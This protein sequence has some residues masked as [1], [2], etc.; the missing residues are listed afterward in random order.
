MYKWVNVNSGKA[1]DV[2]DYSLDLG[3]TVQQWSYNG[4]TNQMWCL[5]EVGSGT[6]NAIE[7]INS[8]YVLDV[9][10]WPTYNF[11][12]QAIQQWWK[13]GYNQSYG[14]PYGVC[15]KNEQFQMYHLGSGRY[16]L[17]SAATGK[18]ITVTGGST[19]DG[20]AV[21]QNDSTGGNEQKW[22]LV[23]V[24]HAWSTPSY[25]PGFWN[26]YSYQRVANNC[27]NYGNN[28]RT[29][30][31]AQPGKASGQELTTITVS[32]IESRCNQDQLNITTSSASP[33]NGQSKIVIYIGLVPNGVG[34]FVWDFHVWRK[35]S[36]GMWSHKPGAT[37]ATN[38]HS[39]G[40]T[41]SD[42]ASLTTSQRGGYDT[43]VGYFFTP[44]D[45]R[46][47][48]GHGNVW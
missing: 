36:N 5:Q 34:G 16:N 4:T 11:N 27:Y 14:S 8:S 43:L 33:P 25:T 20:A 10:D 12:G 18:Y 46:E 30:S 44:S 21:V 23:E 2:D 28:R 39:G 19:S 1:L 41:I 26:D 7:N 42:P 22:D 32:E 3:G 45:S 9:R 15:V 47:G 37:N 48:R 29:D 31:F 13:H 6:Y 17:I 38:L 40:G 35:D 24:S